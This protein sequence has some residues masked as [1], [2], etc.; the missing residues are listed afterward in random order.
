MFYYYGA[1]NQLARYYQKPDYDTIIEPFAGSAAYSM[2]HLQ[3]ND[4]LSCI[5]IEKDIR[6][7]KLWEFL[8]DASVKDIEDYPVPN[9][10]QK[11]ND[12][13]IMTC[14]ASNS[15]SK[16]NNLTYTDRL[17]RVFEIQ[18]KR[19]LKFIDIKDRV[20]VCNTDYANIDNMEATWFIDPPYQVNSLSNPNTI[21]SNGNGYSKGC[22]ADSLDF[23]ELSKFC[24]SRSG[25]TIVC[26]KEGADWMEFEF[27]RKSKTSLN[28]NYNEVV[29]YNKE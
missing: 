10:G 23:N 19:L 17:A 16:C 13:L 1:K 3:N 27:L 28:K 8:L 20:S 14:A 11:T 4:N 18:K 5:L 22:D 24:I 6:V 21:F 12:F 2:Y 26:E 15:I 25:Q 7:Y 9:I 29:W